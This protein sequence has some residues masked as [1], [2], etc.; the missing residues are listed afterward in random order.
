[1]APG[2]EFV[3]GASREADGSLTLY[4]LDAPVTGDLHL[5]PLVDSTA[6]YRVIYY[7]GAGSGEVPEDNQKYRMAPRRRSCPAAA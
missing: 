7:A 2:E 1:M 3:A 6:G 4:S 5:Y